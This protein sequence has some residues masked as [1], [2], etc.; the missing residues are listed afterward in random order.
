MAWEQEKINKIHAQIQRLAVTD[1]EFRRELLENTSGVIER[2]AG[3]RL[4]EGFKVRIIESDP[5]YAATFVLPAMVSDE[6]D[7]K[8]LELVAGGSSGCIADSCAADACGGDISK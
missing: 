7:D 6:I 8:D 3:E 2:I 5:A 1:E 4:P